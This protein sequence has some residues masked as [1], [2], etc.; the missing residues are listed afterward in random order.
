MGFIDDDLEGIDLDIPFDPLADQNKLLDEEEDVVFIGLVEKPAGEDAPIEEP[1][2]SSEERIHR[3]LDSIP[4]QRK[5]MLGIID[6]C[7]EPRLHAEVDDFTLELQKAHVSVYTPIILRQHMEEAGALTYV[8]E[9]NAAKGTKDVDDDASTVKDAAGSAAEGMLKDAVEDATEDATHGFFET[10]DVSLDEDIPQIE[11]LE[12]TKR[13]EG[14]WV[15]TPVACA[16]YDSLDYASELQSA[17]DEEPEYAEIFVRILRYCVEIPRTKSQL[18][19]LVESDPILLRP[20]RRYSGYFIDRLDKC[21]ALEWRVDGW[22]CTKV[23]R[24]FVKQQGDDLGE[25][26]VSQPDEGE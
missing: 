21:N 14:L 25:K 11:Y 17:L 19:D 20:P 9:G 12:V 13:P 15:S 26:P 3:L 24:E 16:I 7:R 2:L 4:A 5:V 22:V 6:F 18:N 23:G 1:E 10:E 8:E